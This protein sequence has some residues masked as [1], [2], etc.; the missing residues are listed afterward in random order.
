MG[1]HHIT[2]FQPQREEINSKP[3]REN[4]ERGRIISNMDEKFRSYREKTQWGISVSV[5]RAPGMIQTSQLAVELIQPH[6]AAERLWGKENEVKK[7][8]NFTNVMTE[9]ISSMTTAFKNTGTWSGDNLGVQ[10]S[11]GVGGTKGTENI[12]GVI[13]A[14]NLTDVAKDL[15]IKYTT[16]LG[17]QIDMTI[18]ELLQDSLSDMGGALSLAKSRCFQTIKLQKK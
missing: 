6:Q 18:K 17:S 13:T 1:S 4:H 3:R 5:K 14:E 8:E 15:D 11:Q 7:T 9:N 16:H 10:R 12:A 2:R